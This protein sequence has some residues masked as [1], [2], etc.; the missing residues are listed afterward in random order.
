MTTPYTPVSIPNLPPDT[1]KQLRQLLSSIKEAL[2]VRLSQ[3]G[4]AL[5]ASPT[6]K[7]LLDAGVFSIKEG[8]TIAGKNYTAEQ[9]LGLVEFSLPSWVTSDVAPPAPVGL[10][11]TTDKTS[12]ILTWTESSFSEY[13][14]TEIWRAT[15]NNLSNATQIGS[16]SGSTYVDTPPPAGVVYYY[17]IRDVSRNLLPGPFNGVNGVGT[18]NGPGAVTASSRFVGDSVEFSWSTPASNLAVQFYR[19]EYFNG[20]WIQQDVV[21]GNSVRFKA[22]WGGTRQFRIVAIDINGA[23]GPQSSFGVTVNAHS[24]PAISTSFDGEQL[25]VSWVSTTGSLPVD[26]YEIYQDGVLLANLLAEQSSTVFRTKVTWSAKNYYVRAIDTAGNAGAAGL[27]NVT[28]AV[29]NVT[30]FSAQVLDNNVLLKWGFTPGSLPTQTFELRRG[31]TWAGGQS[32]G[33]KDGG[34]TIVF[35]TPQTPTDFTYWIALV[36]TAGNYGAPVSVTAKVSQPPDYVLATEVVSVLGGTKSNAILEFG[37]LVIPINTT[38]TYDAH[39]TSRGWATP[40]AQIDAGFPIFIQPG[41]LTGYYE[42]VFDYGTTL[43]AMKVTL[44]YLLTTI[45]GSV[46]ASVTI[47]TAQD[48][49]F[50]VGVQNFS[51]TQ[52]FAT[53]FRYVRF[54]ITVTATNNLG[55]AQLSSVKLTLDAKLKTMSGTISCNS[56]D[57]GGTLLYL[58]LDRTAGGTKFFSDVDSIVVTPLSTVAR[59]TAYDFVDVPEPLSLKVLLFDVGGARASGTV[60][61]TIRG[62]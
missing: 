17:W 36:D 31:P 61:Y 16:T 3:R 4:S 15:D 40:Q 14:H 59:N 56:G 2:E 54:R 21:A 12:T 53:N 44:T 27:T 35:E 42:E 60:S 34:F 30:G 49:G 1:P 58:T 57:A 6:F 11:L 51:S 32:I 18:S 45:A 8:I 13:L 7:D 37:A 55:I 24:A 62:Y 19:I 41:N 39:F 28:I 25:V 48:A 5:D 52:A 22:S 10:V 46:D 43:A 29:G 47:T 23:E 9:L 50:T 26:R 33:R 38:E 20:V